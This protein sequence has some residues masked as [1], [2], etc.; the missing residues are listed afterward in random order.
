MLFADARIM[1]R[2]LLPDESDYIV[3]HLLRHC[4]LYL[5]IFR[6]I[7]RRGVLEEMVEAWHYL[8]VGLWDIPGGRIGV[9]RGIY[10][11]ILIPIE[12]QSGYSGGAH[13]AGRRVAN[14]EISPGIRKIL[15]S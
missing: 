10:L 3:E 2:S 4:F 5:L 9:F 12:H 11:G 6:H 14:H 7:S 15:L 8:Y 13:V 1:V